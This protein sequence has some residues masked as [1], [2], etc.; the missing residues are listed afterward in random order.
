VLISLLPGAQGNEVLAG[1]RLALGELQNT[2]GA[3]DRYMA[4]ARWAKNTF[5]QLGH[6]TEVIAGRFS[7]TAVS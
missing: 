6:L 7:S 3:P 5:R 4:Y 1:L 2:Y